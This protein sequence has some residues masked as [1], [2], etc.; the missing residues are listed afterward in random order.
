MRFVCLLS[1]LCWS[2]VGCHVWCVCC[3]GLYRWYPSVP[4]GLYVGVPLLQDSAAA[5]AQGVFDIAFVSPFAWVAR[6]DGCS[7][8]FMVMRLSAF[9]APAHLT[10][11]VFGHVAVCSAVVAYGC[12][13]M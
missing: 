13:K 8:F 2:V 12:V 9:R 1:V 6:W 5:A 3:L 10:P 4:G 7:A 11:A